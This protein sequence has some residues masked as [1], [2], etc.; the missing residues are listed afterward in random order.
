MRYCFSS[1]MGIEVGIVA[2]KEY[3]VKILDEVF[4]E[5]I[6]NTHKLPDFCPKTYFLPY[7]GLTFNFRGVSLVKINRVA[8]S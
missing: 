3:A 5:G 8:L 2:Y 6:A 4:K 1:Q 7:R